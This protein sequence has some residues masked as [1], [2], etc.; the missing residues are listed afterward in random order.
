VALDEF[1]YSVVGHQFVALAILDL[2]LR[3]RLLPDSAVAD[4][5][6]LE[7]SD[8]RLRAMAAWVR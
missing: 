8:P 6:A 4:V 1:H 7:L 2:L 3:D 5:N